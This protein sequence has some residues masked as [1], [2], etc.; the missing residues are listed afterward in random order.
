M[1]N[2]EASET[3]MKG[4]ENCLEIFVEAVPST[5][6]A[7]DNE[8]TFTRGVLSFA[9]S[10]HTALVGI[11]PHATFAQERGIVHDSAEALSRSG[12]AEPLQPGDSIKWDLYDLLL[13]VHPGVAS[14]VHLWGYKALLGWWLDCVAWAEYRIQGSATSKRT[15]NYKWRLRWS[16]AKFQADRIN[17]DLEVINA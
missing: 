14:K 2:I 5:L 4:Q 11:V 8:I 12:I 16:P 3:G 15:R 7:G 6:K 9:N 13:D 17:I 10:G 1:A